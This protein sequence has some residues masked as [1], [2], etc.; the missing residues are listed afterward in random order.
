[1]IG[2]KLK[3]VWIGALLA[4]CFAWLV[5]SPP[6]V[7]AGG[8]RSGADIVIITVERVSEM[9]EGE[10]VGVRSDAVVVGTSPTETRTVPVTNIAT[11]TIHHKSLIKWGELFGGLAGAGLGYAIRPRPKD[12]NIISSWL[13]PFGAVLTTAG[14]FGLGLLVG[15][16]AAEAASAD[17]KYDLTK[18]SP[19]QVRNVMQRLRGKARVRD[20]R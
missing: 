5:V 4:A 2:K 15:G 17:T 20:Y 19:I 18:M 1:M 7:Q 10:L 13:A 16:L 12:D 6:A 3:R 14:G 11:I 8:G 9:I